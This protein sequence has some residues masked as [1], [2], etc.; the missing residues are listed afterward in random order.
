MFCLLK[1]TLL[2]KNR[3]FQIDPWHFQILGSKSLTSSTALAEK[4]IEITSLGCLASS[5]EP[6]QS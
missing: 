1:K 5:M 4:Q 3:F 2:S 6:S